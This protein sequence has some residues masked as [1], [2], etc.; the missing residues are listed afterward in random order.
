MNIQKLIGAVATAVI[1]AGI[2]TAT[3]APASATEN[4]R[5]F[6]EQEKLLGWNR[7]PT[8]GYTVDKFGKSKDPVPHNGTLYSANLKIEFFGE[9]IDPQITR[10]GARAQNG[11]FFPAISG[12]SNGEKLYF[13]VVGPENY[14]PN[15]VVWTDGGRDVLAWVPGPKMG[16]NRP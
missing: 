3:A 6:G 13:D 15:S 2:G 14:H 4:I 12:A 1:A 5:A 9:P 10:F 16:G 8:I 7:M 11:A